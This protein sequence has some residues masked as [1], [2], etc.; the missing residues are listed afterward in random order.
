MFEDLF[1]SSFDTLED[2]VVVAVTPDVPDT[3]EWDNTGIWVNPPDD[4]VWI[5]EVPDTLFSNDKW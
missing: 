5:G 2:E 3:E 1:G 4:K